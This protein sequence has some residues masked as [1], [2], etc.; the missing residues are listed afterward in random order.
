VY[1]LSSGGGLPR[2]AVGNPVFWAT[3]LPT[4]SLG[5]DRVVDFVIEVL[6]SIARPLDLA[7]V[8]SV[9]AAVIDSIAYRKSSTW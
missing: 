2:V 9:D 5:L 8:E 4:V 3:V 7:V 6:S 1:V